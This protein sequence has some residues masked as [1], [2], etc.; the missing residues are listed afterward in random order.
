MLPDYIQYREKLAEQSILWGDQYALTMAQAFHTNGKHDLN[1]TF[2]AYIRKA[3]FNGTYLLTGGQNIIF[4][5]LEKNWEFTQSQLELMRHKTILHPETGAPVRL[6]TDEFIDMCKDAKLELTIHAMPE[7]EI[8]FVDEPIYRVHGPL[9]QCL[10]VEAAILNATNSQSLFATLASRLV[11]VAEGA[12]IMEFGLRRAQCIGGLESTRGAFLGGVVGTSNMQAE[13]LY[14]I[15]TSGTM[16]HAFVMTYEDELDAFRDYIGA[17]P[18]NG[19]FLVDTYD[20]LNGVRRAIEACKEKGLILKGI[21][22]DSGDLAYLS[23]K[24]RKILDEAGFTNAKIVASNDLDEETISSLKAQGAKIDIWGVGTNL[25]TSKAQPALGAVY[26]LGAV[27]DGDLSQAEIEAVRKLVQQGQPPANDNFYRQVI[28]LSE[29]AIKTS[30]PGELNVLRYVFTDKAGNSRFN[31]DTITSNW[32]H[33]PYTAPTSTSVSYGSLSF[34]VRSV[35]KDDDTR[36]KVF[37]A[38]T[39]VYQPLQ[40]AFDQGVRV[41]PSETIHDAQARAKTQLG[42]LAAEH[43]RA[44][45]PHRYVAG[46]EEGLFDSRKHMM[47]DI[48]AKVA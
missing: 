24:A 30:L 43:K 40:L 38:G 20:T 3:P 18:Y 45:N 44:L 48:R 33:S 12:P 26:K 31:G 16:A 1:T 32:S 23:I 42:M 35:R 41:I 25:V 29:D 28:K 22:L 36:V 9:W 39:Q 17:M 7:G 47:R 13:E 37:P 19:I 2:H 4:D 10:L 5:W 14:G 34:P 21:R 6:Y 46:I 27:F 11:E 15:P 8:A